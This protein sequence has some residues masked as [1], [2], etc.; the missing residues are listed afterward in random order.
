VKKNFINF[1]LILSVSGTL[2]FLSGLSSFNFVFAQENQNSNFLEQ[3]SFLIE[4]AFWDNTQ[5]C[6]EAANTLHEKEKTMEQIIWISKDPNQLD[7]F[8]K[9]STYREQ[10][11]ILECMKRGLPEVK[12]ELIV[13]KIGFLEGLNNHNVKGKVSTL[14]IGAEDYLRLDYFEIDYD[15]TKN[16]PDLHIY[17]TDSNFIDSECTGEYLG[18]VKT[19]KGNKNYPIYKNLK[20]FNI[21]TLCDEISKTIFAKAN[22]RQSNF[23]ID[24]FF[25]LDVLQDVKTPKIESKI[26]EEKTGIIVGVND[27]LA[28]GT[29]KASFEEDLARLNL[30]DIAI[31]NGESFGLYMTKEGKVKKPSDWTVGPNESVFVS[32]TNTDEI[33]RYNVNTG[34]FLGVFVSSENNGGL[35]GPKDLV[36]DPENRYLYV[37]SFL[38]N[39][40]FLYDTTGN[41]VGSVNNELLQRP[42]NMKFDKNGD[43]LFIVSSDNNK[44]LKFNVKINEYEGKPELEFIKAYDWS[45]HHPLFTNP[46]AV[47]ISNESDGEFYV[48][49]ATQNT[50]LWYNSMDDEFNIFVSSEN[51]GGLKGPKDLVFDPENRY[52]YVSSFLTNEIFRYNAT[53]GEFVDKFVS[54]QISD[55]TNLKYAA[56]GP[57]GFYLTDSEKGD[58]LLYNLK[59]GTIADKPFIIR[60]HGGLD[61]PKTIIFG[62]DKHNPSYLYVATAD[63]RILRYNAET[64][65]A[66]DEEPF[67]S[68]RGELSGSEGMAFGPDCNTSSDNCYLFISGNNNSVV[69]YSLDGTLMNEHF[70]DDSE[71]R[72]PQSLLFINQ[73][74]LIANF[75]TDEILQ[76]NGVTGEFIDSLKITNGLSGPTGMTYDEENEILYISSSSN[77][78]ILKYDPQEDKADIVSSSDNLMKKPQNILLDRDSNLYVISEGTNSILRYDTTNPTSMPYE[79]ITDRSKNLTM[80]KDIG[81]FDI[82][83]DKIYDEVC[84]NDLSVNAIKCYDR[85][86]GYFERLMAVPFNRGIAGIENSVIGPDG[87]LYVSNTL[88]NRIDRH[89]GLTGLFGDVFI[90]T[91]KEP[92]QGPRYLALDSENYI[93]V[94]SNNNHQVLRYNAIT[95]EFVDVLVTEKRGGLSSPQGILVNESSLYVSSNENHRVLKYDK[96]TGE[97]LGDFIPSRKGDLKQPRDIVSDEKQ[98][99]FVSSNENHKILKYDN[100]GNFIEEYVNEQDGLK[101]PEGLEFG[102]NSLYVSSQEE[103]K[104]WE[105]TETNR[106]MVGE[107]LIDENHLDK[108]RG[109]VFDKETKILYVASEGNNKI[110]SYDTKNGKTEEVTSITNSGM[111]NRPYDLILKKENNSKTNFYISNLDNNN[112]LSFTT[113]KG[114]ENIVEV[115]NPGNTGAISPT[116]LAF[117][118]DNILYVLSEKNNAIYK[119]DSIKG[120]L[121]GLFTVL[122][123][124]NGG[125]KLVDGSL[126]DIVFDRD[127]SYLYITSM[128]T[129]EILR[130]NI[131]TEE[132]DNFIDISSRDKIRNPDKIIW[133]SDENGVER[134]FVTTYSQDALL[135]FNVNGDFEKTQKIDQNQ[136][137]VKVKSMIVGQNNQL[138]VTGKDYSETYQIIDNGPNKKFDYGGI[139]LGTVDNDPF[140]DEYILNNINTTSYNTVVIY[141]NLLEKPSAIINLHDNQVLGTFPI[142]ESIDSFVSSLSF[143]EN[144][145]LSLLNSEKKA[146]FFKETEEISAIGQLEIDK[147]GVNA[148]LRFSNFDIKYDKNDYVSLQNSH[149][150]IMLNGP[151]IITCF[152]KTE[153]DNCD[154]DSRNIGILDINSGDEIFSVRNIDLNVYDKVLLYDNTLK[155]KIA[156]VN[157]HYAG[158]I[159]VTPELFLEWIQYEFTAFP[160][161][162]LTLISFPLLMDYSRI[163]VKIGVLSARDVFKK[164]KKRGTESLHPVSIN[165]KVTILI[166]AHNE[167]A[168]I[169]AAIEASLRNTYKNKEIIVIDDASKDNTYK[170]AKEYADKGLIKVLHREEASGSK[171]GALNYGFEFSTGDLIL[172]MDGDTIL[173]TKSISNAVRYF[174]KENN[175]KR[176]NKQDGEVY[177]VSG[178]VKI[179]SGDEGVE[180]ILTRFQEY[181]YL[182]AIELGRTFTTTFNML[183]IISGAFGIFRR[184][185]FSAIGKFDKD[186]MT[187]DFDLALKIRKRKGKIKFARDSIAR[188]YCPNNWKAWKVQRRRWA[189]GHISTLYKHRDMLLSSRFTRKD[190]VGQAD[191]WLMDV[192]LVFVFWFSPIV[193]V[194]YLLIKTLEGNGHIIIYTLATIFLIYLAAETVVFLYAVYSSRKWSNL[195]L[196][197]LVPVVAFGYRILLKF[198][199]LQGYFKAIRGKKIGW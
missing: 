197:Y 52:L 87:E 89:D 168:G 135:T 70:V 144:P 125:E 32:N 193:F 153:I 90:N 7:E 123:L 110:F 165:K 10:Q 189:H 68:S 65:D 50:I 4:T 190:R 94:T 76:Y 151:E 83:N 158:P 29:A 19:K 178:N 163:I 146:G 188:T 92:L 157:I 138:Y 60:G 28:K 8:I 55:L 172:C 21:V 67:I 99:I 17:L 120:N 54:S 191:M 117:G 49:S 176:K 96:K 85:K 169:R 41:Y 162:M 33:L 45:K 198:I 35:K 102:E 69:Q 126:R 127:W 170:I 91:A 42:I 152:V 129:N 139:Y 48:S 62:P 194:P 140:N 185:I 74:L 75:D 95:G 15:P 100:R 84:V 195:K 154:K 44:V 174:E 18:K 147:I 150:G 192:I 86:T 39:E 182:F 116:G 159:K 14:T 58:I 121:L 37:S 1:F 78:Q 82:D 38:T 47:A 12:S 101:H 46:S 106:M 186:T 114:K 9:N 13:N 133:K 118:P 128:F 79:F 113:E 173:D 72:N 63:N 196:I 81:L 187:E 31:S 16:I 97:F 108:P 175:K 59:T 73:N 98:N 124:S 40:I 141:D 23:I 3:Q 111:L 132:W 105:F 57:D 131:Q 112:L 6:K 26:I 137:T 143:V 156:L 167:E 66:I 71:L 27:I 183:M 149:T 77:N 20:N 184:D 160:I 199:V 181:E 122:P 11:I 103:N 88:F 22:L 51:N 155:K 43:F 177:A 109:L 64:G 30:E 136:D 24:P 130:Y 25:E 34:E 161:M 134:L 61:F 171:A 115:F 2:I 93:Y 107:I 104:V 180:N 80:P 119:Y 145:S 56:I 5:F 148:K 53:T 179:L 166:P 164:M 36:F 142:Q